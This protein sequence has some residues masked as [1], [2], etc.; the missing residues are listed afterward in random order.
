MQIGYVLKNTYR[1]HTK[2]GSK[3]AQISAAAGLPEIP[4]NKSIKKTLADHA[5]A[6]T[7]SG[8]RAVQSA[9]LNIHQSAHIY[10]ESPKNSPSYFQGKFPAPLC[11]AKETS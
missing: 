10:F 2:S 1:R 9:N 8:R 4:C 11:P 6:L 3:I 7:A 5:E